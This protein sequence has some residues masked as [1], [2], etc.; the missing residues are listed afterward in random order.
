[1]R[2]Y[3]CGNLHFITFSCYRRRALLGRPKA[4]DVFLQVL[5]HVR[6]RFDFALIGYVLMPEHVHLLIGEPRTGNPSKVIQVL[7]QH[8]S[9]ALRARKRRQTAAGQLR[10]WEEPGT[11]QPMR[12]WQRRFYDFNVWSQRKKNEKLNYMHFNP[13]KREIVS[14][15]KDWRWSSYR[16]YWHGEV[17]ICPPNPEWKPKKPS[18]SA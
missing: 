8:V 3:G 6:D 1:V 4:R 10:L 14:H 16:Y 7:K 5:R 13:V 9:R 2:R 15:P 17:G 12:F 11:A 18:A